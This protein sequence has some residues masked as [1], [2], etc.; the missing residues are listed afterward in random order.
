MSIGV[1]TRSYWFVREL[2]HFRGI[3]KTSRPSVAKEYVLLPGHSLW[4]GLDSN[5]RPTDYESRTRLI[6]TPTNAFPG[7]DPNVA[8]DRD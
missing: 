5:Q 6:E 2:G 3:P 8:A 1:A 4:G 7:S